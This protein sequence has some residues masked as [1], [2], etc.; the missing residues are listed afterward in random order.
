M[1]LLPVRVS[2]SLPVPMPV[3]EARRR[4]LRTKPSTIHIELRNAD[5]H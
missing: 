2:E 3:A 1:K 4:W 5:T